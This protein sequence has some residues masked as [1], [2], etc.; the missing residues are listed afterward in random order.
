MDAL[1]YLRG[2]RD[3]DG[4]RS[5]SDEESPKSPESS[6]SGSQLDEVVDILRSDVESL[7]D[8]GPRFDE[9]LKDIFE[10]EE[11]AQADVDSDDPVQVFRVNIQAKFPKCADSLV[12]AL[13]KANYDTMVRL[14]RERDRA[15]STETE[16][17]SLLAG[18]GQHLAASKA[19]DNRT[20]FR[21]SAL[22]T[23]LPET[24]QTYL[25]MTSS[26]AQT[27][28]SFGDDGVTRTRIPP[29]PKDVGVGRPFPCPACGKRV[30]KSRNLDPWK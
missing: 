13:S 10:D 3:A 17:S 12:T 4:S 14:I 20:L 29:Q 5:G 26:Y 7:M 18:P 16:R 28:A 21:D 6:A 15:G 9:P 22:G 30:F 27:V 19:G 2:G 25:N 8:L 1:R 24:R 23:S 11:V